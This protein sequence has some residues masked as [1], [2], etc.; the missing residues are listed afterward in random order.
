MTH[1][2]ESAAGSDMVQLILLE[3]HGLFGRVPTSGQL[4]R[5]DL[6]AYWKHIKV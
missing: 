5:C 4:P 6:G 1:G 2:C 3:I